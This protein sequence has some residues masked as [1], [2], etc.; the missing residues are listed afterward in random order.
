MSSLC[1]SRSRIRFASRALALSFAV[2]ALSRPVR[3]Q[4]DEG[5]VDALARLLA[6]ADARVY[7]PTLFREALRH[8]DPFVRRQAALAA[9]R[10]GDSAAV[11][12]LIDVL[13]DSDAAVQ[14]A[15]AFALGLLK[16][17]RALTALV[18][19]ARAVP[20]ERQGPPH[21]EAVTAIAKTGGDDGATALRDLL[22]SGLTIGAATSLVQRAALLEAWR[23]G[24][25][26]PIAALLGYVHDPDAIARRHAIYSLARLRTARGVT[27]V[28]EALTDPDAAVRAVALRGLS[29]ALTDSAGL[30]P[31][32]VVSRVRPLLGDRDAHVRVNALRALATF[33]DSTLA[34][35][36]LPLLDDADVNVA[37]QA[38]TTL[39]VLGGARAA[40]A[41][42]RRLRRAVF[43]LRRQAAIAL[44][45]ADSAAGV[46]AAAALALEPDWRWR[47]VAAE[48]LGAAKD[49]ARLEAQLVDSDGRVAVQ[50]LQAL[51][52]IVSERDTSLSP[53]ARELLRHP[54]AAVRSVAADLLARHPV[55]ADVD[56]LT[57]A[58]LRATADTFNDARLSAV[59]ALAAI[60]AT[61]PD[62]RT[63]VATRFVARVPRPDDYLVRRLAAEKL[64][65]AAARWG[66]MAPIATG[67]G[68][69][70]YYALVQ[71]HV[72]SSWR[73]QPA[74]RVII[75]TEHGPL[76]VELLPVEAPLTVWTFLTLVDQRYFDR[77]SWHRVV[78]NFVVQDGDPRGDGWG[79]PGFAL[80]DEINPVRYE[81]GTVGMALSGPDTGGSQ[82]FITH[83]PQPHLDGIYTVFG[84]VVS[85]FDALAAI[86]QG[87]RIRSIHR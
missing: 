66:P 20:A 69:D 23:L 61:G 45:Q 50:A 22:G 18:A 68:L 52:R 31:R 12:S 15:A 7:D 64:P 10:I 4:R 73:G 48:A 51:Q 59:A 81:T 47:S 85:G 87:E 46:G 32:D 57:D 26:A 33:H 14:A 60:A 38:E 65:D 9:G 80:R 82:F 40:A 8:P 11:S 70:D 43:A 17:A 54:D 79:G 83:S 55:V 44:A 6:A 67:R 78:P 39:G 86:G 75:E 77:A 76:V 84:R 24:T 58:Y 41:L 56:R 37:V 36:A 25:R 62:A 27:A 74:P 5:P 16:P 42:E 72:L 34:V 63:A 1:S 49:P 29:R 2:L 53:R 3:A 13:G 19:L 30:D 35:H 21:A 71:R 28:V